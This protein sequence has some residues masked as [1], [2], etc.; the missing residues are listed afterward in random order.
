MLS[1]LSLICEMYFVLCPLL[2]CR[3]DAL[4]IKIDVYTSMNCDI[5]PINMIFENEPDMKDSNIEE[6][7]ARWQTRKPQPFLSPME[8]LIQQNIWNNSLYKKSGK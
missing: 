2:S 1:F 8:I 6:T 4:Q 7:S 5:Y 3:S